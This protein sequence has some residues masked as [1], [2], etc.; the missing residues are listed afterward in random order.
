MTDK[1]E[2]FNFKSS[3][4]RIVDRDGNPWFIAKDVCNALG[5]QNHRKAVSE[6]DEDEKDGVS[7]SDAIG[8][9]QKTLI[10][11]ESG[12]YFIALRSRKEEAKEFARWVRKVVLPAVFRGGYQLKDE[13]R[14]HLSGLLPEHTAAMEFARRHG[15][16][17]NHIVL[18]ADK[19]L[20]VQ[21][22][23]DIPK[24]MGGSNLHSKRNELVLTPTAIGKRLGISARD[25]NWA[26]KFLGFQNSIFRE[27]QRTRWELTDEGR[28][29]GSYLDVGKAYSDGT[30]IQQIK[31]AESVIPLVKEVI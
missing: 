9:P 20:K 27:N 29:Y 31:W 4:I 15:Y 23:V 8:R 14:K 28:K 11:S 1:V 21:Y 12:V 22:G 6:L 16:E 7:I 24:L 19:M 2:I 30:P 18:T 13:D 25:T 26:L 5:I 17:G 10:I 3:D